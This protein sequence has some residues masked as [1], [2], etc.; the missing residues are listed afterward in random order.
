MFLL[1]LR[2]S[3]KSLLDYIRVITIIKNKEE[4]MKSYPTYKLYPLLYQLVGQKGFRSYVTT[5]ELI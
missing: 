4:E 3:N 1:G 2:H 5:C